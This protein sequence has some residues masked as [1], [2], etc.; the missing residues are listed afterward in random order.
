MMQVMNGYHR[1]E[2]VSEHDYNITQIFVYLRVDVLHDVMTSEQSW[3]LVLTW[4]N[5]RNISLIWKEQH[6]N[7]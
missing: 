1:L 7:V 5:S 2:G 4:G 6:V 3:V